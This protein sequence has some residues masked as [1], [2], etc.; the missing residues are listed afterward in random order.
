MDGNG[1]DDSFSSEEIL[2]Q[3][4][5]SFREKLLQLSKGTESEITNKVNV[6]FQYPL[7][8]FLF[9]ISRFKIFMH[10]IVIL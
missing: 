2:N 6:L 5:G 1:Y 4:R 9:I 8:Y 3:F 7:L 10:T